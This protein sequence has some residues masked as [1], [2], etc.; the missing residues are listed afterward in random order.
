MC[1]RRINKMEIEETIKTIETIEVIEVTTEPDILISEKNAKKKTKKKGQYLTQ[2]KKLILSN[3]DQDEIADFYLAHK[4]FKNQILDMSGLQM[5][6]VYEIMSFIA[7]AFLNYTKIRLVD[8]V[9]VHRF[10]IC[11]LALFLDFARTRYECVSIVELLSSF[12]AESQST[13]LNIFIFAVRM[14]LKSVGLGPDAKFDDDVWPVDEL[15]TIAPDRRANGSRITAYHF[16]RIKNPVSKREIKA[17]LRFLI[18]GT[19]MSI[20]GEITQIL[21]SLIEFANELGT[22][23][24]IDATKEDCK[25][26]I[27]KISERNISQNSKSRKVFATLNF[28]NHLLY[29][30]KIAV[31]P[32]TAKDCPK[33]GGPVHR[34]RTMPDSVLIQIMQHLDDLPLWAQVV[35]LIDSCTGLRI[36][37]ITAIRRNSLGRSC[38]KWCLSVYIS[39]TK[40]YTK[41]FISDGVHEVIEDY[42][43]ITGV[44]AKNDDY[45]FPSSR[46]VNWHISPKTFSDTM[47]TFIEKHQIVAPDGTLYVFQSTSLRHRMATKLIEKELTLF[48]VA[49][50]LFLTKIESGENYVD[51]KEDT[52]K[53]MRN[54]INKSGAPT[55]LETSVKVADGLFS[56]WATEHPNAHFVRDGLC[57]RSSRFGKCGHSCDHCLMCDFYRTSPDFLPYHRERLNQLQEMRALAVMRESDVSLSKIDKEIE[58][59]QKYIEYLEKIEN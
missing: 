27:R 14:Y 2:D 40:G 28:Y 49:K 5:I 32:F 44:G 16:E 26:Y 41:V 48:Y 55:P 37:D 10:I 30:N 39:K 29:T 45:M 3:S 17:Y 12:E 53:N 42:L 36:G 52:I 4:A 54:F 50:A 19:T 9:Y 51:C 47:K 33:Q 35:F 56:D 15:F 24:V 59:R 46:K 1:R 8:Y 31:L 38:G 13:N 7:F 25:N 18:E 21:G 34:D 20:D 58:L 57:D 11:K 6:L 43:T 22:I 23:S